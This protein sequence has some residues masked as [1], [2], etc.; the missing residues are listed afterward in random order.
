MDTCDANGKDAR[1]ARLIDAGYE[2]N[3]WHRSI[4]DPNTPSHP[5]IPWWAENATHHLDVEVK[6]GYVAVAQVSWASWATGFYREA[7]P[8]IIYCVTRKR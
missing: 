5:T 4:L 7:K 3:G 1:D 8:P 2:F 6:P